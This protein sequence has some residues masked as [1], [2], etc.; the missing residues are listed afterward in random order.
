MSNANHPSVDTSGKQEVGGDNKGSV[1]AM[2][3]G[4]AENREKLGY[5]CQ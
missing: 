2:P 3:E 5:C 4:C 1:Q